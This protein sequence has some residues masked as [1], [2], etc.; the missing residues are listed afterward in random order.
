MTFQSNIFHNFISLNWYL[1]AIL[2]LSRNLITD[3]IL[4]Y[5]FQNKVVA[6]VFIIKFYA[7]SNFPDF[8]F[9]QYDDQINENPDS[10]V[11]VQIPKN[12]LVWSDFN[13]RL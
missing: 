13:C 11:V 4:H 12:E 10:L 3:F 5:M 9:N 1:H 2:V 7:I 6:N 8:P